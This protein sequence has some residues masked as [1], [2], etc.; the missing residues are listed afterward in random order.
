MLRTATPTLALLVLSLSLAACPAAK[1]TREGKRHEAAD[2]DVLAAEAYLEALD[3]NPNKKRAH[4]ALSGVARSAWDDA[5]A[6]ARGHEEA[7]HYPDAL[8]AYQRLDRLKQGLD[9]HGLLTFPTIDVGEKIVAMANAAAEE[10]YRKGERAVAGRHWDVAVAAYAE[11][12]GFVPGYKDSASK[13]AMSYYK[14]A[15][16]DVAAAAWRAGAEH[17]AAA[18]KSVPGYE[19]AAARGAGL[20]ASLGVA[21]KGLGNCRQ[22]VRDLRT[23][24][25]LKADPAVSDALDGAIPCA[26]TRAGIAPFGNPTGVSPGGL[27]VGDVLSDAVIAGLV[28]GG[29]EFLKVE[30]SGGPAMRR[31]SDWPGPLHLVAGELLQ[32]KVEPADPFGAS[33][34]LEVQQRIPCPPG[35]GEAGALCVVPAIVVYDELHSQPAVSMEFS[36]TL[37]EMHRGKSV[38]SE[39]L[40]ARAADD[41]VYADGLRT[42]GGPARV[43]QADDDVGLILPDWLVEQLTGPREVRSPD[44]LARAAIS[45][46]AAAISGRGLPVL[47]ADPPVED[48]AEIAR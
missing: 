18:N 39:T 34:E 20:Y 24:V 27:A 25:G 15:E 9:E 13:S 46:L 22:A 6:Q 23:S 37:Q 8:A 11:A 3:V 2:H 44:T 41:L 36:L 30:A 40:R 1:L 29:S 14:W 17:Y 5:L 32:V 26:T 31:Q 4:K 48:P 35:Q 10:Q 47:D 38:L 33:R 12:Q 42:P 28:R 19:D 21:H 45:D 7:E 43:A 16:D